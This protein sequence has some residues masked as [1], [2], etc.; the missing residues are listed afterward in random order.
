MGRGDDAM[1]LRSLHALGA[2]ALVPVLLAA[3]ATVPPGPAYPVPEALKAPADQGLSRQVHA[4]GVQIYECKPGKDDAT[5][6]EWALR[7]PEA[8]LADVSG[9]AAG[10]HYAGPTWEANDGSKVV[11]EVV[12]R[13]NGPDATAIPW[14]LLR[15]TATTGQGAFSQVKSIQRLHTA[16]GKAPAGGCSAAQSGELLRVPYSADYLF[17]R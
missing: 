10:R 2:L 7:G 4:A 8:D 16:G 15:A 6:F 1:D 5:R 12:A 3:C 9:K 14:L 17:Y 13:D 11:G